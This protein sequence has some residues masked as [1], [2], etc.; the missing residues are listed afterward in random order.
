MLAVVVV[1]A[2]LVVGAG[3]AVAAGV[4]VAAAFV[5]AALVVAAGA[6]ATVVLPGV[7][8]AKEMHLRLRAC[9]GP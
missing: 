2:R 5:G 9:P 3:A 7:V 4:V 8:V 1:A 6:N